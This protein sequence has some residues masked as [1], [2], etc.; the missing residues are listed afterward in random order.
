MTNA[1]Y[2]VLTEEEVLAVEGD[3]DKEAAEEVSP[4]PNC[5]PCPG[6]QWP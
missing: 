6:M 4:S 1:G 5:S 3:N 2:H